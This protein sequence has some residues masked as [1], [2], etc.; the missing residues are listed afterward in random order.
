MPKRKKGPTVWLPK[1]PR[2]R[3]I[4]AD[5][6]T[7]LAQH[8]REGT[9]PR[10]PRGLF[11]DLRPNGM[12]N[13]VTYRKT[14]KGSGRLSDMTAGVE[15]VQEIMREARHA[16]LID[17]DLVG[18]GRSPEAVGLYYDTS[19]TNTVNLV[20]RIVEDAAEDY[21]LDPQTGQPIRLEVWSEA[22][23][24]TSRLA[25]IASPLGVPVFSGSGYDSIKPVRHTAARIAGREVPTVTLY[26]G[27]LDL[28]GERIAGA[29]EEDVRGWLTRHHDRPDE[30]WTVVR[31]GITEAQ[32]LE[33]G[34]LDADGHAEADALPVDYMD[35][36]LRDAIT[37]R[38]DPA[39]RELLAER[40][41]TERAEVGHQI[42]ERL[43]A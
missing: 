10:S 4:L 11:Y 23:D 40:V 1:T 39:T 41:E 43:G 25:R 7:R 13:G 38:T 32:A 21:Q 26:I 8:V 3:A 6:Q 35:D 9:A 37:E 15:Q 19:V 31:L 17:E 18:D 5:V 12:G 22:N 16:G 36:L 2:A 42:R 34:V 20:V 30:W 28:H 27:D 14:A 33:L 29:F 24:L